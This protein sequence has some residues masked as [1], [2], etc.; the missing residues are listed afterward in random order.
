MIIEGFFVFNLLFSLYLIITTLL[1]VT[2]KPVKREKHLNKNYFKKF[3][4]IFSYTLVFVNISAAIYGLLVFATADYPEDVFTGLY[5]KGGFGSHSLSVVNFLVA[6]YYFFEK[7]YK[8]F[9]FFFV[10]GILGFYGQ[11]LVIFVLAFGLVL[12][13]VLLKNVTTFIKI[14]IIGVSF[15]AV[16]YLV[17]PS[18]FDYIRINIAYANL[19]FDKFDYDHEI[20]QMKKHRRTWVPRYITFLEGS[21]RLMFSD[22]K[23]L[24]LGTSPGTFNSRVAF[25]LNGD[26]IQNKTYKKLFNYKTTYHYEYVYPILNRKYLA[27][28]P[29][30]D[31]TRNQPFSS[32]VSVVL[33]YGLIAG[34]IILFLFFSSIKKI[35][36]KLNRKENKRFVLFILFYSFIL[37][38]FQYYLEVIEIILPMVL[39][40][41]LLEIDTIN[42]TEE[43]VVV[44]Q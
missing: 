29:W 4:K 32:L 28:V 11:G 10:C 3:F 27:A 5:G 44:T 37:F 40:V 43:N 9:A 33:E 25:Y 19:V 17:N 18:N 41:K 15:F 14:G 30:N 7:K 38:L 35:I 23:V 36:E 13:P 8:Q 12:L 34:L 26:F 22:P 42:T 2:A 1:L 31:G 20:S 21:R 24:L 16:V 6:T 39:M